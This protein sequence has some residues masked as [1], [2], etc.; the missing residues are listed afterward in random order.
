[1]AIWG[2]YQDKDAEKI[3]DGDSGY[4]LKEYQIAFGR[5]WTLWLGR[6]KDEPR[7]DGS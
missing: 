3:D 5:D 4:L 1:M 2:R 7:R 6:K